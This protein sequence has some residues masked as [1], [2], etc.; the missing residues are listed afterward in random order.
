VRYADFVDAI[1]IAGWGNYLSTLAE[2]AAT[3][4]GLVFVSVSINLS[5]IL[6]I[7]GL[8]G[9]A[10]ESIIQLFGVLLV[11]TTLLIPQQPQTVLGSELVI[12]GV[13]LWLAQIR[14]QLRYIKSKT[15]HPRR[16]AMLRVIQSQF[17]SLPFCVA[18]VLLL[19]G[20]SAALYW[21]APGFIFSLIAGCLSAWVMLI[22]ILR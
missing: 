15:G 19:C 10:A 7:P 1:P 8:T 20:S 13:L 17:A 9:R 3:L 14:I 22:E 16:W 6:A 11:A 18:G 5:R 4:T 21:L 12:L 2:A